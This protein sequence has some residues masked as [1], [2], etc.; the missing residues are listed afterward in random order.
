VSNCTFRSNSARRS[1]AGMHNYYSGPTV[2]NCTFTANRVTEGGGGAAANRY[3]DAFSFENCLFSGNMARGVGG[4]IEVGNS[5]N[6]AVTNCTFAGNRALVEGVGMFVWADSDATV[7]NCI[8]RDGLDEIADDGSSTITV[9]YSDVPDTWAG[10]GNFDADPC[11]AEDG[12]WDDNG[13]PEDVNDDLWVDGDYHLKSEA[14]RWDQIEKKWVKDTVTSLC[15]DAGD[16]NSDWTGELWPHG[17]R[18][19]VGAYGGLV[20]A[21][22]SLLDSGAAGNLDN[23]DCV[24]FNDIALLAEK[25][26]VEAPLLA[27]DLDRNGKV[28]SKDFAV[29]A[30]DWH[31]GLRPDPMT[32]AAAPRATSSSTIA[33]TAATT[34]ACDGGDVEYYFEDQNA[35]SRNSG[36]LSFAPG[37]QPVW[38]DSGLSSLYTYCYRVKARN[39]TALFETGWSD[40]SCA[41][42]FSTDWPLVFQADFEDGSLDL[43]EATD[44]SAWRIEDG[45]GGKVLSLFKNSSYS[46]P[47]YSPYNINLV[48]DVAVDNFSLELEVLS[49][50]SDYAHRDLCLFFGYQDASHFYYAHLGK[51]ADA[52]ANSIFIVDGADRISIADYRTDGIPW[53]YNWHTVRV[54]RDVDTGGIEVYFDNMSVPVMTA[55]SHRF[56]WGRVGVG[57]FDD[58]GQFDDIELRGRSWTEG[59]LTGAN[60]PRFF[61][62][63]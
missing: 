38:E 49:T 46:P 44:P 27:E 35:P 36:W 58:K 9:T 1:G 30:G 33:V 39:K 43:W 42:P 3:A 45:H 41:R 15:I 57:S 21:S 25:W 55:V 31:V 29:F 54:L 7:T 6:G 2:T 59:D 48:R 16:P 50:N 12:H 23:R 32:W 18:I 28:D 34:M 40:V 20:E 62:R 61:L 5:I 51:T 8:F 56:L 10:E 47:F 63:R 53:D 4:G 19:N 17:K 60:M 11:F 24:D 37:E 14:G 13:T 52:H 26:C 22:M